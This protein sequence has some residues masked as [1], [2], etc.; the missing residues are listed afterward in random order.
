MHKSEHKHIND[1]VSFESLGHF[2]TPI[3]KANKFMPKYTRGFRIIYVPVFITFF[4]IIDAQNKTKHATKIIHLHNREPK[5]IIGVA[6][7]EPLG[8]I[9][10]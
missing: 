1:D 4:L 2:N 7:F 5:H 3:H 9:N 6:S 8:Y 10:T